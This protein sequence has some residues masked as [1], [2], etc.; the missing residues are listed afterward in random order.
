MRERAQ[1]CVPLRYKREAQSVVAGTGGLRESTSLSMRLE[2][3]IAVDFE[4]VERPWFLLA[5]VS[6]PTRRLR[7]R[8]TSS[9]SEKLMTK[10]VPSLLV[11]VCFSSRATQSVTL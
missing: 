6:S 7:L 8:A 2:L 3:R 4:A 5:P 1:G 9:L 10:N 11:Q